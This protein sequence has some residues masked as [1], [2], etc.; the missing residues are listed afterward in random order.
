MAMRS[1]D[2]G[3]VL[4]GWLVSSVHP[5]PGVECFVVP[6]AAV[7]AQIEAFGWDDELF[8]RG[9]F[10]LGYSSRDGNKEDPRATHADLRMRT[11]CN[12]LILQGRQ[13]GRQDE[14]RSR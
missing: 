10:G 1:F 6:D 12:Q 9:G 2:R 3:G 4:R 8:C 7:V 11:H 5:R 14:H 13:R